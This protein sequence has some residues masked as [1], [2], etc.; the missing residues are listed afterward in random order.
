MSSSFFP[1]LAAILFISHATMKPQGAFVVKG[2]VKD[3]AT[4]EPVPSVHVFTVKG[5]EEAVTNKKGE[6]S[7]ETWSQ[8]AELTTEKEGYQRSATKLNFPAPKQT[9]LL[10]KN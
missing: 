3:K 1:L 6:F 7:F 5:E 2:I 4:G 9:L 10:L 8:S